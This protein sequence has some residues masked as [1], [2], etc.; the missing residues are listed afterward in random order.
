MTAPAKRRLLVFTDLDGTLLDHDSYQW[1][2]AEPALRRLL[3]EEIPVI[4]VSSKT[5]A[6]IEVLGR[7]LPFQGPR[8]AENGCVV[9]L[10]DSTPEI[11]PPGQ[12]GIRA[13]LASLGDQ[14]GIRFS[15][16]GDMSDDQLMAATGLD[17]DGCR[18]ARQR[19]ASEALLWQGTEQGLETF[20]Q[21]VQRAGLHWLRGGRFLHILGATDKG[22]AVRRITRWYR[23]RHGCDTLSIGLGDS[24]NDLAM[25]QAVD[26]PVIVRRKD[27]S[28]LPAA[29]CG[30]EALVT[31]RP[32][33]AG[34]NQAIQQL[35]DRLG[36]DCH[37]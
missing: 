34:W 27:G 28:H 8:V 13:F 2:E 19:L 11:T 30:T 26:C 4:P 32:G 29:L 14:A 18:L 16:L 25:L 22:E 37:G 23:Q 5:L 3:E 31:E 6:E 1:S 15:T 35:L 17:R 12:A 33:P 10:D 7:G 24:D 36:V 20:K 9:Q 21:A